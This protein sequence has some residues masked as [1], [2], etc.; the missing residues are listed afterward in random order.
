M[1]F[2]EPFFCLLCTV[3]IL[4]FDFVASFGY[5]QIT[6]IY[7]VYCCGWFVLLAILGLRCDSVWFVLLNL[8]YLVGQM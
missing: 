4:S 7:G 2:R 6:S 8:L 3:L 5:L 1:S